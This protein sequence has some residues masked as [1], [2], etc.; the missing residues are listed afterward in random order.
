[1]NDHDLLV[2]Y[3]A[4][5]ILRFSLGHHPVGTTE[6]LAALETLREEFTEATIRNR[7]NKQKR[8]QS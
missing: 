1:M 7:P 5:A 6:V 2:S 8:G 3:I 4:G